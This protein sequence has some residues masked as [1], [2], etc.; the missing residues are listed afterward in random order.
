MDKQ[1][2][3]KIRKAMKQ[4]LE[5]EYPDTDIP[6]VEQIGTDVYKSLH[7]RQ[8]QNLKEANN[9]AEAAQISAQELDIKLLRVARKTIRD[10]R[11]IYFTPLALGV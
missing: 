1:S 7:E 11:S 3:D 2:K 10:A 6:R 9:S 5:Q 8:I 4:A